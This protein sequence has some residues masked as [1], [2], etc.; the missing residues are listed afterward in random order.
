MPDLNPISLT[1]LG[2]PWSMGAMQ[3][4]F[5]VNSVSDENCPKKVAKQWKLLDLRQ[6]NQG[7]GIGDNDHQFSAS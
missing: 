6:A 4:N 5:F 1:Y 7:R 3:N 2:C